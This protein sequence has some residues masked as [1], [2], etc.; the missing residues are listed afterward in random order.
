MRPCT[1][2]PLPTGV[3][4]CGAIGLILAEMHKSCQGS[5]AV[6]MPEKMHG[7]LMMCYT[8]RMLVPSS[9]CG[10]IIGKGGSVILGACP[11][12]SQLPRSAT[13]A[14]APRRP[15]RRARNVALGPFA[16]AETEA[17]LALCKSI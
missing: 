6:C 8:L 9:S 14:S 13:S 16:P 12:R 3:Q 1:F 7:E 4:V 15:I 5:Q 2:H 17:G 11:L 10:S